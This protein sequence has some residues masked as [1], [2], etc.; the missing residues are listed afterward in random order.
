MI[1]GIPR[2]AIHTT[3][4]RTRIHSIHTIGQFIAHCTVSVISAAVILL[5]RKTFNDFLALKP[6]ICWTS[7]I[8]RREQELK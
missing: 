1:A 3:H 4:A 7:C 8:R 6:Q 5:F 2:G